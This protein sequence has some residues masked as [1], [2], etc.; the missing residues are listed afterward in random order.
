MTDDDV[1]RERDRAGAEL[2][3]LVGEISRF[4]SG[5][6]V[7]E[8]GEEDWRRESRKMERLMKLE[9]RMAG[10]RVKNVCRTTRSHYAQPRCGT[11]ATQ[12]AS[13]VAQH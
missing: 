1:Y 7:E 11:T 10:Q 2:R 13:I 3:M 6:E 8:V 5:D 9:E 12:T 4:W